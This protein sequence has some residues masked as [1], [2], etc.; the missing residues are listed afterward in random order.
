MKPNK[1]LDKQKSFIPKKIISEVKSE[2]SSFNVK[3]T[4]HIG[5][6]PNSLDFTLKKIST[7]SYY[8]GMKS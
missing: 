2:L 4:S 5:D 1:I 6:W 7:E 3:T 8:G